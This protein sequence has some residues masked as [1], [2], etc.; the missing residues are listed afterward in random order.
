MDHGQRSSKNSIT[1]MKIG[2]IAERTGVSR[3]AIRLYERLG[4]LNNVTRPHEYNNYKNYGIENVFRINMIKEMQRIGLKLKECKGVIEALVN[5][6]MDSNMRKLFISN[7]ID[8]VQNKITSLKQVKSFLQVHLDNDCA[9]N[10][11][12]MISNLKG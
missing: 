5:D 11:E 1:F 10:S 7:K 2:E 12:S 8:E 3:D 6:E 9:Y 4:L